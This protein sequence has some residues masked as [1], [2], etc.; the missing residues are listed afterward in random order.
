MSKRPKHIYAALKIDKILALDVG[1][2]Y[3]GAALASEKSKMAYPY[4][5]CKWDGKE[6]LLLS[7]L[8]NIFNTESIIGIVIG[9]VPDQQNERANKAIKDT[10]NVLARLTEVPITFIDEHVSTQEAENRMAMLV[11]DPRELRKVRK[12]AVAAQIIL[13]RFFQS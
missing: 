2:K 8:N 6:E 5:V 4:D 9:Y 1:S 13:E 10:E 11:E 3:I 12:D 7:F